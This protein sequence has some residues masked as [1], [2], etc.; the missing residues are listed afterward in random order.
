M[1]SLLALL[2]LALPAAADTAQAVN[3]HIR[4]GY[5]AFAASARALAELDGCEAETLRPAF[6]AAYDAWL[7]VE[8]LKLGPSEEDGRALAI[9]FWP[10]PK[11]LGVK[12]QRGL[13]AAD[14]GSLT[15]DAMAEQSVAARGL[16]GLERLLYPAEPLAGDPCPL[17]RATAD[18]LAR[19]ADELVQAWGPYG[20]LLLTAGQSGNAVYLS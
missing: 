13:L 2:L 15:P 16:S 8:H 9:H 10:D 6:Q 5:A 17:I 4:P 20:D 11:G 19:L 12:A 18:D 3:D 1:R 14:P 7:A